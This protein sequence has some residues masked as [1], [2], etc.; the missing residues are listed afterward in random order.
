MRGRLALSSLVGAAVTALTAVVP[1]VTF[2]SPLLGGAAAGLIAGGGWRRGARAGGGAGAILG[3]I[4][5]VLFALGPRAPAIPA[6]AVF[7][8]WVRALPIGLG[9]RTLPLLA[10]SVVLVVV[11]SAAGGALAGR[12]VGAR[13]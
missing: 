4:G 9:F 1:F 3:A 2:V 5:F 11:V 12:L 8:P 6:A 7:G 13:R 10:V